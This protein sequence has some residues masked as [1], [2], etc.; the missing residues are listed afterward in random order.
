MTTEFVVPIS[1]VNFPFLHSIDMSEA[2]NYEEKDNH[3]IFYREEKKSARQ[4]KR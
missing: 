4:Q 1:E 3:K 2:T